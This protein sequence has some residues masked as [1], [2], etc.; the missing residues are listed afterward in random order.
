MANGS[1]CGRRQFGLAALTGAL[2]LTSQRATLSRDTMP[3]VPLN[4]AKSVQLDGSGNGQVQMT[5][6]SVAQ[7]WNLT[8]A[9]VSTNPQQP[10]NVPLCKIYIGS[11]PNDANFVDGTFTG[12]LDSTAR[13]A[14]FPV[15]KGQSIWA[16]WSGADANIVATLSIFGTIET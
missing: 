2:A 14:Q 1:V 7:T 15:Q 9:A 12:N 6:D 3:S 8:L 10:T 4:A 16:V 5:P 11:A 13:V